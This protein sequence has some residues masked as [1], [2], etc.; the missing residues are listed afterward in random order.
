[1]HPMLPLLIRSCEFSRARQSFDL[2]SIIFQA[3]RC[4]PATT[5]ELKALDA[6]QAFSDAQEKA[7]E[8]AKEKFE[9]QAVSDLSLFRDFSRVRLCLCFM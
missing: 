5:E 2:R 1:M 9:F 7:L 6:A 3:L 4:S 8:D